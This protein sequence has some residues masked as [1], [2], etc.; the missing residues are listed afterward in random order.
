MLL[1]VLLLASKYL[2]FETCRPECWLS[3]LPHTFYDFQ[4]CVLFSVPIWFIY[5][6]L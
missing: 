3:I 5:G 2:K 6:T 4:S 1:N